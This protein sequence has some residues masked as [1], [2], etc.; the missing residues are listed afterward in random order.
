MRFYVIGFSS[1]FGAMFLL[2]GC[3]R[4]TPAPAA[5]PSHHHPHSDHKN[6]MGGGAPTTT[7]TAVVP[8]SGDVNFKTDHFVGAGA[9]A[10]CHNGLRDHSN[11]DVSLETDW[12]STMMANS[13]R[14][15]LFRAKLAAEIK[16][17]PALKGKIEEKCAR[18]HTPMASFETRQ[19]NQKPALSGDGFFNQGNKYFSAAMDGVSCSF[20]HQVSADKLGTSA[21][22]TGGYEI[23]HDKTLYGPFENPATAPM[24]TAVGYTPAYAPHVS[25]AKFCSACHNLYTDVID[26]SGKATGQSFGEQALYTEWENSQYSQG[27]TARSCQ[28]CHMPETL[29]VVVATGTANLPMRNGFSRHLFVGGNT[30]MLDILNNNKAAL[31]V[32]ANNFPAVITRTR[33]LLKQAA[34]VEMVMANNN[35]ALL[36]FVLR[37]RNTSGHKLPSGYLARRAYLHVT[38]KNA[39]GAI[40]FESGA[41][42]P[43][44]SIVGVDADTNAL[45]YEAHFDVISSPNEVQVYEAI[46]GD[47]TGQVN[48]TTM[49]A[50]SYLKDNRLLPAGAVAAALPAEVRPDTATLTDIN[51]TGGTDEVTYRLTGLGAGPFTVEAELNYQSASFRYLQDLY[52]D[53]SEAPVTAFK[54]YFQSSPIRKETIANMRY[55]IP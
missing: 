53:A 19:L 34:S 7:P 17:S 36:E 20:C 12:G 45:A 52:N 24:K 5:P 18:C 47:T 22:F 15:P 46:P 23:N 55:S 16:R 51:F 11:Q 26:A 30:L 6:L 43:D 48:Y 49:R 39:A 10:T 37:V 8:A 28:Y 38:V 33:D 35:N 4:T 31:G 50:A 41:A 40:V 42:N 3:E 44:G 32:K 2:G 54:G 13:A 1:L 29:G 9:C 27:T 25:E 21:G 14:D